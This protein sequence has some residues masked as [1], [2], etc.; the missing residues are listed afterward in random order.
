MTQRY[1]FKSA[2]ADTE[3]PLRAFALMCVLCEKAAGPTKALILVMC[4]N[5]AAHDAAPQ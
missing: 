2:S 3:A 5:W 4:Q 1:L